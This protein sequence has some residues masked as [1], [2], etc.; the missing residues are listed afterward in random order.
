MS[1]D[2][3]V[4]ARQSSR[5]ASASAAFGPAC[6]IAVLLF[7]SACRNYEMQTPKGFVRFDQEK[8]VIKEISANGVR[9]KTRKVD[10]DPP[11]DLELWS[12]SVEIHLKGQGYRILKNEPIRTSSNLNGR[13]FVSMYRHNDRDYS[14]LTAI[15]VEGKF[16]Y[17]IE[18]AGLFAAFSEHEGNIIAAVKSF[19]L[20]SR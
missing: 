13:L 7:C 18:S 11:G 6:L 8:T 16:V 5:P 17:V 15:F 9:I 14:F 10:N 19:Q 1:F 20:T 4:T 2:H 3:F 12:Q